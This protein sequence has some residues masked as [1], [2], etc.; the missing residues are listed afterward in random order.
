T[1]LNY[2]GFS[3][4]QRFNKNQNKPRR[5]YLDVGYSFDLKLL[6]SPFLKEEEIKRFFGALWCAFYLG[7]FGSRARRGFGS[8]VMK[9]ISGNFNNFISFVPEGDTESWLKGNYEKIRELF[10][11]TKEIE[12]YI[13]DRKDDKTVQS[14][15]EEVQKDRSGKYLASD[16]TTPRSRSPYGWSNLLNLMGFTLMAFRS[17]LT[18]DYNVAK[19]ILQGQYQK[20]QSSKIKIQKTFNKKVYIWIAFELLFFIHK[21]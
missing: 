11:K 9:K 20:D 10:S 5:Q 12:I 7:N 1:G 19:S 18:P 8:I 17:Y 3:L 2:I 6:F 4:D 14:W 16:Y 13:F 15:V 21:K